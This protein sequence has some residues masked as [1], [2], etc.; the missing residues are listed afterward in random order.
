MEIVCMTDVN[1]LV[2]GQSNA[3]LFVEQGGA[4]VLEHA[5]EAKLGVQV[6]VLASWDDAQGLNT[7]NSATAFMDWS[8]DGETSGLVNYVAGLPAELRDNPTVT[9]WMHNEYDQ[10]GSATADAWSSAVQADAQL[11]R[12]V[13]G[14]DASTT[15]YVFTYVPYPYGGN[16]GA[17]QDGMAK[18]SADPNFDATYVDSLAGAQMDRDGQPGGSHMNAA[19]AEM[20]GQRLADGM[21]GLVGQLAGLPPDALAAAAGPTQDAASGAPGA[22]SA[23]D[24]NLLAAE[25]TANFVATGHW[26]L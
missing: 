14:Q 8:K 10:Q 17:I 18:L 13:L 4:T 15:P 21:A 1:I 25:V 5:L 22:A 9:L 3:L 7:I 23:V 11:V 16:A 6:N 20:A 24:W 12:G 26:F 2:R 19:D